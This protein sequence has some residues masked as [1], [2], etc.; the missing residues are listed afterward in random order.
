M[1][2]DAS[3]YAW[4]ITRRCPAAC[5]RQLIELTTYGT[6]VLAG[7]AMFRIVLGNVP[8]VVARRE[9]LTPLKT[10]DFFCSFC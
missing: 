8:N 7:F 4:R 5:D 3:G 2:F 10:K 6:L 1:M 9:H